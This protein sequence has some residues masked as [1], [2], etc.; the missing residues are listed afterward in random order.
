MLD[1]KFIREN[2]QLVKDAVKNKNDKADIDGILELDKKRRG[3]IAEVEQLKA[4]RNSVSEQIAQ[5][6]KK[7]EDAGA[8][9]ARMKEVGEKIASFDNDLRATEEEINGM[10][11]RVPNV[12][13]HSVPV[14]DSEECN[15]TVR[16]WG[17]IPQYSFT[18][19]PHWEIGE[20]LGLLDLPAAA[21]ITGSGFY[22]LKGAGARLQRALIQFMLDTHTADGFVEIA[23]PYLANSESMTGTGQL[24]KLAE[25]MYKLAEENLYLIPTAEVPVTNLHRDEILPE[26]KLPI[27]YVA[28]TPCFRREAGAAGKDTRGMIRVHQFEKVELVKIVHPDKSY[29]EHETLL[30]QA[31]KII[32]ALNIPYRV[33]LLCTGDL[34]FAGAKCYDIEIW[35]AGVNKYL[36]ISSVSNFESFQA[37][38]MNTRFRDK[39]KKVHFVHTLNGSGTALARLVPAIMENYQTEYGTIVI[40]EALRPYMGGLTE[41]SEKEKRG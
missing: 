6:K 15:V 31:E 8:D 41:I 22:I 29:D 23:P 2:P 4:L 30:Q 14:G 5:K 25:D 17:K 33:R 40:P 39:D 12:P 37:R 21:K 13:H 28:H 36:E 24:P 18:P 11:L 19:A 32:R 27:Y 9:I 10:L 16:E 1:I 20:K 38:R 34:S 26:E 3:I 35:C 7:K